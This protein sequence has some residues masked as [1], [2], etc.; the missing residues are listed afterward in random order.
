MAPQR[1]SPCRKTSSPPAA[2]SS[3]DPPKHGKY[4]RLLAADFTPKA[5][6]RYEEWLRRLVVHRLEE[7]L[8]Q[9]FDL[10]RELAA[11]I[12]IRVLG[13]ILGLPEAELPHL[14]LLGDRLIADTEPEVVGDLAFHGERAEDRYKP[15]GSPWADELCAL[16][17]THYADRRECPRADLVAVDRRGAPRVLARR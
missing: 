7:A 8:L 3:N 15:F 12:P 13:H 6:A 10:V 5:I 2:T 1:S 16:G 11:P 4:R 17:R 14:V 9:E